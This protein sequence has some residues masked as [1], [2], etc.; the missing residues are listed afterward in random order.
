MSMHALWNPAT[1]ICLCVLLGCFP[2]MQGTPLPWE[3]GKIHSVALYG[4][5]KFAQALR[6]P[7]AQRGISS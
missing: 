6:G 3:A 5:E 1:A 2:T 7:V 4:K